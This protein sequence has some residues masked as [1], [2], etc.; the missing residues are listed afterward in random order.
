MISDASL[1]SV[2]RDLR[3]QACIYCGQMPA[4]TVDHVP[5]KCFFPAPL[6][7]DLITVPC[8]PSC[9][10]MFSPEDQYAHSVIAMRQD[11]QVQP[12]LRHVH[13]KL[14]RGLERVQALPLRTMLAK[15]V[16]RGPVRS[17]GGL[18]LPDRDYFLVDRE[19]L[20]RWATRLM[21]GLYAHE[22]GGPVGDELRVRPI[23]GEDHP[24][25]LRTCVGWL[26]SRPLRSAGSYVIEY[27]WM[28]LP[29]EPRASLWCV[30]LYRVMPV[31]GIIGPFAEC[32]A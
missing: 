29:D 15:A 31:L 23:L 32:G 25:F 19:R 1:L 17:S 27:K 6:P 16:R 2:R 11:V 7:S 12:R 21:R 18:W 20:L 10:A 22:T 14:L 30:Q 3:S 24:E 4:G 13:E 5:P 8:C 28:S 26:A 9:N